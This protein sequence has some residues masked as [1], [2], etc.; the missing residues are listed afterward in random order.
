MEFVLL[1]GKP[2]R[3]K[4]MKAGSDRHAQLEKEV[5]KAGDRE[6]N[7]FFLACGILLPR[8]YLLDIYNV[9]FSIDAHDLSQCF[10]VFY[11]FLHLLDDCC[12]ASI[13]C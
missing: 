5:S 13:T 10:L 6:L 8:V 4:A 11:D 1:H 9:S 2:R 12:F 3:T 7:T